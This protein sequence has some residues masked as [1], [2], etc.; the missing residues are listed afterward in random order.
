MK[1]TF[2]TFLFS[3]LSLIGIHSAS[4]QAGTLDADFDTDGIRVDSFDTQG[5]DYSRIVRV[6]PDGKIVVCGFADI[7]G[8]DDIAL[9][10][11]NTDG[12]PDHTFSA[13]GKATYNMGSSYN[14]YAYNMTTQPDGKLLICG[15]TDSGS[16]ASRAILVLRIN[17]DGSLDQS[18]G[19][20]G[21]VAINPNRYGSQATAIAYNT[22]THKIAIAGDLG[23]AFFV[24]QMD[25]TGVLDASFGT[26]GKEE[27]T[28][29][30]T[31]GYDVA[32]LAYQPDG[33]L[34]SGGT[35]GANGD[36]AMYANRF[37]TDGT[38]DNSFSVD[39][40][41]TTKL[42]SHCNDHGLGMVLQ[43]DGKI[44]VAGSHYDNDS[45]QSYY[46]LVRYAA[47]GSLDL[48]F[49]GSGRSAINYDG[50]DCTASGV[51]MAAD[52][53]YLLS[54]NIYFSNLDYHMTVVRV[55][56][57]GT[58]DSSFGTAGQVITD[59]AHFAYQYC[60]NVTTTPDGR[61]VAVGDAGPSASAPNIATMRY[62]SGL[63]VGISDLH[64]TAAEALIYPNP[65]QPTETLRYKL[66]ADDRVSILLYNAEGQ[67][68]QEF[69]SQEQRREGDHTETLYI[70]SALPAGVYI[71]RL[72]TLHGE[73]SIRVTK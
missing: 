25:S 72:A 36:I 6:L 32:T 71:L 61:I 13:D 19:S 45:G 24:W 21:I 59:V 11:Y 9:L 15:I 4:A 30:A 23:G 16:I 37:N 26:G 46:A 40:L 51:A 3:F 69:I 66:S 18:F 17:A 33:R 47:D 68:V 62:L 64:T 54:G 73:C 38:P 20:H 22:A 44:L 7:Q 14:D 12:T 55:N 31:Y 67:V 39:G 41:V 49:N 8:D 28:P 42:S 2:T 50:H 43:P 53:K 5:G 56:A 1:V 10:K 34:V 58:K 29:P 52:G 65:L 57:D 63:H 48:T 35:Y 27:V 60:N 70:S